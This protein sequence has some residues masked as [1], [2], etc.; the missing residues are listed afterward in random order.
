MSPMRLFAALL[1]PLTLSSCAADRPRELRVCADPNNLPF[2]NRAGEG[3]E[4]KLV[5]LIARELGATVRYTWWAQRRGNVR[6]TLNEGLCD[7]IPGIASGLEML[8]TTRPYYRS[9]YV[10]LTRADRQLDISSFDDP[11]LRQLRIGVQMVGDD[12]AN[13]PP[14]HALARRGLVGNVRGYMIYG[15]YGRPDPQARIVSAVASNEVDIAFV[16]GPVGSYFGRRQPVSLRVTTVIAADEPQ[17]MSF[18]V[19]MGT[20]RRDETLRSELD[21]ILVQRRSEIG[22]L[23]QD[24]GFPL[25]SAEERLADGVA[26]G[27]DDA[28]GDEDADP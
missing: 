25:A 12:F 24:Y 3:L 21:D 10:V 7:I 26:D 28:E 17:R 27:R 6:E 8:A 9:T 19:S 16:W 1:L 13:T 4:N 14:A 15:D 23:L 18:G 2:S 22:T 11:R 5:D 20:R